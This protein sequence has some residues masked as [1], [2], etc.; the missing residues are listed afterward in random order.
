MTS[1]TPTPGSTLNMNGCRIRRLGDALDGYDA[2]NKHYVDSIACG[3]TS[4]QPLLTQET[5]MYLNSINTKKGNITELLTD[6]VTSNQMN[7]S[8]LAAN[9]VGVEEALGAPQISTQKLQIQGD[10]ESKYA[11]RADSQGIHFVRY[12]PNGEALSAMSINLPSACSPLCS[13]TFEAESDVLIGTVKNP[14][15]IVIHK[16]GCVSVN[17]PLSKPQ[18]KNDEALLP[19]LEFMQVVDMNLAALTERVCELEKR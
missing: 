4:Y 17:T 18:P 11:I 15:S 6:S 7:V 9:F 1:F 10:D 12:S 2:V 13:L 16:D 5:D 8:T 3:M 19:L 14:A